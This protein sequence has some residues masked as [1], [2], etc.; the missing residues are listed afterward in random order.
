[1]SNGKEVVPIIVKPGAPPVWGEVSD[2][3]SDRGN[4]GFVASREEAE[5]QAPKNMQEALDR[6][7]PLVESLFE[8]LSN[9]AQRPKEVELTLGLKLSGKVGVI[10]VESNGEAALSVKMKWEL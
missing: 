4:W 10:I 2:S 6:I 9:V 3:G 8:K 5:E 7:K 1:M